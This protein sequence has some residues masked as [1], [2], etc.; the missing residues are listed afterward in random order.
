MITEFRDIPSFKLEAFFESSVVLP[1]NRKAGSRI[2]NVKNTKIRVFVLWFFR[3]I[4]LPV[5]IIVKVE[6][7]TAS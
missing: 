7:Y 4:D 2:D 5:F 1:A 3:N 6:L